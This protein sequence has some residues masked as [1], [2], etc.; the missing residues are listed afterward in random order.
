MGIGMGMGMGI[1]ITM[2]YFE[3]SVLNTDKRNVDR[4]YT[5][6]KL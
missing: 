3:M 1:G 2:S 5:T 4:F 6:H